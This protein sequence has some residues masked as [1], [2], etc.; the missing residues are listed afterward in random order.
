MKACSS[1]PTPPLTLSSQVEYCLCI[2][3]FIIVDCILY[4][5]FLF[6]FA[7]FVCLFGFFWGG[8]EGRGGSGKND[9][10][11]HI[12]FLVLILADG[13]GVGKHSNR[14]YKC[15]YQENARFCSS[16]VLIQN[17]KSFIRYRK[18]MQ[19]LIHSFEINCGVKM[20]T[21]FYPSTLHF[22]K[23]K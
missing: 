22:D 16:R 17:L 23:S 3:D 10:V 13:G 2:G 20:W 12:A 21:L 5:F 8:G 19:S 1:L 14:V 4:L 15:H 9:W 18:P 7:L 11:I 6:C